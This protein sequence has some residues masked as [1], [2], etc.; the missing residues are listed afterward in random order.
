MKTFIAACAL[1]ALAGV[2]QSMAAEA[3]QVN[4]S[5]ETSIPA[6]KMPSSSLARSRSAA[7]G[8]VAS[9][10]AEENYKAGNIAGLICLGYPFHPPGKPENLRTA[11]LA[12]ISCPCPILQGARDP[13]GTRAEV[14]AFDLAPAIQL[15]WLSD[16]DHDFGPRGASGFTRKENL[17]SAADAILAFLQR[18]KPPSGR[19]S[20]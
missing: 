3:L 17:T 1:T 16:G 6:L 19:S 13:F 20:D 12:N 2:A 4:A 10:I 18:L 7:T 5:G 11:H 9:M 8:R 14:E 15:H